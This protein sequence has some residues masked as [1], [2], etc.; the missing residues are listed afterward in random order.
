VAAYFDTMSLVQFRQI[1]I[2]NATDALALL[3]KGSP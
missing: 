1:P 2:L 3:A